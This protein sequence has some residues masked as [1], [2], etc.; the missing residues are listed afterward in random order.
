MRITV[1]LDQIPEK[2]EFLNWK[3]NC[4]TLLISLRKPDY[5]YNSRLIKKISNVL[6]HLTNAKHFWT[7]VQNQANCLEGKT[8]IWGQDSCF[9]PPPSLTKITSC[10]LRETCS[11]AD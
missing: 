2:I 5:L 6:T 10:S 4:L 8:W 7:E 1:T 11:A 3:Q 9:S